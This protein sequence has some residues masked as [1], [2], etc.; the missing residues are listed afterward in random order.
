MSADY[1]WLI[2][3]LPLLGFIVNGSMALASAKSE[4]GPSVGI[5]GTIAT[6]MPLLSLRAE[7]YG[8]WQNHSPC[9]KPYGHGLMPVHCASILN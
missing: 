3:A 9:R 5:V 1:L 7:Y 4:T 2:P 6:L 8:C